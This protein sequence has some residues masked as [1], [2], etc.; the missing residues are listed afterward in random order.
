[1]EQMNEINYVIMDKKEINKCRHKAEKRW[2]RRLVVLNILIIIGIIAWFVCEINDNKIYFVELKDIA[3]TSMN[4]IEQ[5]GEESDIANKALEDK[6]NEFPDSIMLAGMVIGLLIAL[7]FILCYAYAGYRSMSVK[8][9]EKNFPEIYEFVKE[10][11]R[12]L[13]MKNVPAVY[14]VQ[15]NGILNAFASCIPFKQYIELYADLVEVAY[16]EHQDMDTLRFII[17][18]EISHIHL[19]HSKLYYNYSILFANMIPILPQIASRAREYSCDRLGQRLSGSDGIDAMMTLTAGK[20]LYKKVDKEDYIE[21]AKQVKGF[22]VW[23]YNLASSHPVTSK[24]VLALQMKE[25][26][27]KLY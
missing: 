23:C 15:G 11:S 10:Y 3:V 7:P 17:A 4:T 8:V 21:N 2:Y 25:G 6:M 16:R 24:R 5:G 18:H 20:H 13:G 14:L 26:S 22:F 9:T 19:G 1:M 12:K 27:G